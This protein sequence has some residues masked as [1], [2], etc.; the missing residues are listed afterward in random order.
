MQSATHIGRK[1]HASS[2]D[3]AKATPAFKQKWRASNKVTGRNHG[4]DSSVPSPSLTS[5][6]RQRAA[7]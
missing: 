5:I 6:E 3:L 2:V 4:P 1:G 7:S